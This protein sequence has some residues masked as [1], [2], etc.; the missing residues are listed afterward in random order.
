MYFYVFECGGTQDEMN[1]ID[2]FATAGDTADLL[3]LIEQVLDRKTGS[4]RTRLLFI[5]IFII[6]II[7]C[8]FT[9]KSSQQKQSLFQITLVLLIWK[10][11]DAQVC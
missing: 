11:F 6:I 4:D 9:P 10:W 7:L 3:N 2:L 5:V 8:P 1:C